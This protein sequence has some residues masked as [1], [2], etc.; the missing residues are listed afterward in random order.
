MRQ[1]NEGTIYESPKG[2]GI[3]WAQLAEDEFGKR[4]KRRASSAAEALKL[5]REMEK[6]REQGV[7]LTTKRPTTAQLLDLW[8]DQVVR[9]K[10]K[11]TTLA[12]YRKQVKYLTDRISERRVNRLTAPL[13]Q[14]TLN[15]LATTY[16][17][18]SRISAIST[19][20]PRSA[21]PCG[22]ATSHITWRST[23][24]PRAPRPPSTSRQTRPPCAAFLRS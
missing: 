18:I 10:V 23:L 20:A 14:A 24:S 19:S 9:R 16:R 2:S 21:P 22:G 15:T 7:S 17:S 12:E 3:W 11:A 4:P 1:K 6:E 8:L 5:L 13:I